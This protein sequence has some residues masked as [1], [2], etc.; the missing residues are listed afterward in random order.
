MAETFESRPQPDVGEVRC[1]GLHADESL[2][3][4][5]RGVGVSLQ[6]QL[7]CEERAVES[8]SVKD[9]RSRGQGLSAPAVVPMLQSGD[10]SRCK[11]TP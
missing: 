9:G 4:F 2:E 6:Q 8:P 10:G 1:L 5:R 7:A 3:G 11:R